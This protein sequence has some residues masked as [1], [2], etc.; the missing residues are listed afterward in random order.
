[1]SMR[2]FDKF[3]EKLILGE[4]GSQKEIFDE[5]QNVLRSRLAVE[6]LLIYV[7]MTVLNSMVTELFYDWAES[8]M[9]VTLLFTVL[10]LLWFEIRCA[11]KGCMLAVSGRYA[12]KCSAVTIIIIG[13][14]NMVR[15]VFGI[16]EEDYFVADGKLSGDFVFA[17]CFVLL[18]VCGILMLCVM[19]REEK[20]NESGGEK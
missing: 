6:A 15:Y 3:C 9:T 20:M 11:F 5:R 18:I 14:L 19:R 17:L 7:G 8:L 2:S 1:M 10:C 16:G 4:P 12:Q 13:A